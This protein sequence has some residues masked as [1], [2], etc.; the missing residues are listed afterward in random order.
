M[1]RDAVGTPVLRTSRP[2]KRCRARARMQRTVQDRPT[3]IAASRT[4]AA[5]LQPALHSP[6]TLAIECWS[7]HPEAT[8]DRQH[9]S[10]SSKHTVAQASGFGQRGH[11][12]IRP[13]T[14]ILGALLVYPPRWSMVPSGR[15]E[16][17]RSN[18]AAQLLDAANCVCRSQA[19]SMTSSARSSSVGGKSRLSAFAPCR[20][21]SNSNLVDWTTVSSLRLRLC[22]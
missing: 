5:G 22:L 13:I 10:C 12:E 3:P 15:H 11:Q 2:N 17:R 21:M 16:Y 7:S 14:Q 4:A 18:G 1:R 8:R 19:Y 9:L 20:L 6:A